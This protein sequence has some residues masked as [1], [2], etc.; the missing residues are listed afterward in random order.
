MGAMLKLDAII[1]QLQAKL[2][3]AK[4]YTGNEGYPCPLCTYKEGVAI[5][6]CTMHQQ[7]KQLQAEVEKLK[8]QLMKVAAQNYCTV[9]G[10]TLD[11]YKP[12][13]IND[14]EVNEFLDELV[15]EIKVAPKLYYQFKKFQA[16]NKRLKDWLVIIREDAEA[17]CCLVDG[18][19][20]DNIYRLVVKRIEDVLKGK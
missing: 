8:R 11:G 3:R 6:M 17:I 18:H 16:E 19:T 9:C 12:E 5:R 10:N 13:R 2:E 4:I 15:E 14:M 1:E 7:I 20:S